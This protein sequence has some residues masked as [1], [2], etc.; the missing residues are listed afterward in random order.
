Q[1]LNTT[2]SPLPITH[3]PTNTVLTSQSQ[4]SQIKNPHHPMK[5]LK[6]KLYQNKLQ[7]HQP[8][9]HQIPPQQ[10]QIPSPTQIPSYLFH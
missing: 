8:D 4:P 1:H 7:Q 2:H 10:K 9:L 6:P 3:T 5:M